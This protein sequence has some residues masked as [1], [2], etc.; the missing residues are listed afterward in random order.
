MSYFILGGQGRLHSK[1]VF[2][3]RPE[4]NEIRGQSSPRN[5]NVVGILPKQQR[6]QC[7]WNTVSDGESEW[8]GTR[9]QKGGGR[10]GQGGPG[11]DCTEIGLH[12]F[13]N[14]YFFL[15]SSHLLF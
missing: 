12:F 6:G 5:K 3:K 4:G 7:S 14:F 9:S 15:D 8:L 13:L 2:E 10:A 11:K 1:E